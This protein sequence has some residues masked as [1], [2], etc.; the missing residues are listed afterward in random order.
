MWWWRS[1]WPTGWHLRYSLPWF[2]FNSTADSLQ[3][4]TDKRF[5]Q[6]SDVWA[7]GTVLWEIVA[8][9]L[10]FEHDPQAVI[11]EKLLAGHQ[12]PF[13]EED[14]G[15]PL[16]ELIRS[17]WSLLPQDRPKASEVAAAIDGMLTDLYSAC[18]QQ[19]THSPNVQAIREFYEIRYHRSVM[20]DDR[21]SSVFRMSYRMSWFDRFK[22]RFSAPDEEEGLRDAHAFLASSTYALPKV[23]ARDLFANPLNG[24]RVALKAAVPAAVQEAIGQIKTE[25]YWRSLEASGDAW[26]A[27][28]V[29][30]PHIILHATSRWFSMF[31]AC[32]A[33]GADHHLWSLQAL[34]NPQYRAP[35]AHCSAS[36]SY[37]MSCTQG[38]DYSLLQMNLANDFLG[39]LRGYGQVHGMLAFHVIDTNPRSVPSSSSSRVFSLRSSFSENT[40]ARSGHNMMCTIHAYPVHPL[41]DPNTTS[42]ATTASNSPHNS[43]EEEPVEEPKTPTG[44]S[45]ISR[46]SLF[47][48]PRKFTQSVDA[49]RPL[50]YL[51]LFNELLEVNAAEQ[52]SVR[53]MST[54][55]STNHPYDEDSEDEDE[56]EE[57]EEEGFF[58]N[59]GRFLTQTKQQRADSKVR[60]HSLG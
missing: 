46:S 28:S 52:Q 29:E 5:Q 44:G 39:A 13:S 30:H 56:E 8:R 4:I 12:H 14:E 33:F 35:E 38:N 27:V 19:V 36:N 51:M 15:T 42:T 22:S 53:G 55:F 3:V 47:S 45:R 54:S 17:C 37:A 26:A 25:R 18:V 32:S 11:R 20:S 49:P 1:G 24:P 57:D 50:Y 23:S 9:K 16:A 40:S 7:L 48:R 41:I 59:L 34:I 43:V 6:A 10:P 2:V 60:Y 21:G 31:N 58:S